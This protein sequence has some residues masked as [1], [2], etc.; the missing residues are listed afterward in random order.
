MSRDKQ[1]NDMIKE[2]KAYCGD[3]E[4]IYNAINLIL[5]VALL[6]MNN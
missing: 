1:I 2:A 3:D 5:L 6:S 4:T